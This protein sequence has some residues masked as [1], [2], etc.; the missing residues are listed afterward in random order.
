M[1]TLSG[2]GQM[3]KQAEETVLADLILL[4]PEPG[5]SDNDPAAAA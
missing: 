4:P 2:G 1:A 5:T 3:R